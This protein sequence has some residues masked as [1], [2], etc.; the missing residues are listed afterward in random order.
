MKKKMIA[1]LVAASVALTGCGL[2]STTTTS[3]P[4]KNTETKE[5]STSAEP[6]KSEK[7]AS[8]ATDEQINDYI[9]AKSENS[10]KIVLRYASTSADLNGQAYLR[11][12][13]EFLKVL[14]E[15]LGD[16]VEIQYFLNATFGGSADAVLGGLQN[17][18]FEMTDW[19]LGSFAEFTNAFQPLDVP[20]LI[21]SSQKA[22]DFLSGEAGDIMAEKCIEDTGIKPMYYG[23]IG[24]RQLTN[25][26]KEITSPDDLAGLKIRVQNN[27]LHIAGMKQL[28]CAPTA[29]AFS[30]L[31]TSLQ[32]KVIDG[33]ENPI[34]TIYNFQYYEVQNYLS[35]TNHLCTAG[36]V[37]V[38]NDWYEALP[39]DFKAAFEKA[40]DAAEKY[41]INE[42][43]SAENDVLEKLKAKMTVTELTDEQIAVFQAK[44]KEAWPELEELI[45]ADYFQKVTKAAGF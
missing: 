3:A 22:Y 43:T 25:S 13:R 44:E 17:E 35:L 24:M 32:Q 27:P 8:D 31:F 4:P 36:S 38:N 6:A 15:E 39:D 12:A 40:S 21:P 9:T 28:G 41:S 20:Y 29:M 37:A 23:I 45:G 5:N 7:L 34:E 26:K 33:Q 42:L 11:G 14:K 10:A 30:E 19:P 18:T 2:S 1:I 16:K